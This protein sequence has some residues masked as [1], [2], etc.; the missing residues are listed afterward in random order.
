MRCRLNTLSTPTLMSLNRQ[1][2]F[3]L[4]LAAMSGTAR[5]QATA[6]DSAGVRRAVLDYV[7]GFYEGDTVK[8]ARSVRRDVAKLGFA[9][10]RDSTSYSTETMPFADFLAYAG[11]VRARNRPAPPTARKEIVIY[12]VQSVTAS[13]KLTAFWGTEYL[14]LGRFDGRWMIT[15]V[16]W[17]N[18]PRALTDAGV[19]QP[20]QPANPVNL[21]LVPITERS[22]RVIAGTP[23]KLTRDE[24]VNSQ[25]SFTPDGRAVV[26]SAQREGP[27]GQSD[28]YRIDLATRAETRLTTTAENENSPVLTP[29]GCL[30]YT[31]PSPRD[32]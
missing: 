25:P 29:S 1:L 30:L 13:A 9:R 6:P 7:E 22:G 4:L 12:D 10:H 18:P 2:A 20:A 3:A 32:S 28:V 21:Y 15:H 19:A 14:L 11:R 26:F 31:S 17:Q 5:A 8:L 24:G 23:V 27:N 16:L